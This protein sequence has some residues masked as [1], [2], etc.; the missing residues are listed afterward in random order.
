MGKLA[1]VDGRLVTGQNPASSRGRRDA[2]PLRSRETRVRVLQTARNLVRLIKA[3]WSVPPH[4]RHA[5]V[6]LLEAVQLTELHEHN[7]SCEEPEQ[8]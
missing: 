1:I 8:G 3:W 6:T 2:Q 5:M 7:D 4:I